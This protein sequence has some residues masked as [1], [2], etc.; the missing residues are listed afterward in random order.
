M[1]EK[2]TA[3]YNALMAGPE[4]FNM[5]HS[6]TCILGVTHNLFDCD[7]YPFSVAREL[8]LPHPRVDELTMRPHAFPEFNLGLSDEGPDAARRAA[9]AFKMVCDGCD[10][11]PTTIEVEK[12]V[13]YAESR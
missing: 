5:R 4:D 7:A 2:Q 10:P 11:Q 1:T 12:E 13:E 6:E 3:V 8:N 9:I